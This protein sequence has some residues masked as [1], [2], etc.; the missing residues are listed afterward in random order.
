MPLIIDGYNLLHASGILG[1]GRGPGHLERARNALLTIL[2]ESLPEKEIAKTIVVFDAADP[3]WGV[4]RQTTYNGIRVLF[5]SHHSDADSHI[6]E[7]IKD[8]TAPRKLTVVSSDHRLHRAAKR[9]KATAVDSD[10]W[11]AQLMRD[12]YRNLHPDENSTAKP[13][14]PNSNIEVEYW[15]KHFGL[16]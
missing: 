3:P 8:D 10:L 2:S 1:R 14:S 7:L 6:E 11:F 16:S 12:R 5:A 15:L 13:A 9:R 4:A